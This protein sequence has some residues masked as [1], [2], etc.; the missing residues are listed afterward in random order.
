M[1]RYVNIFNSLVISIFIVI[2]PWE[3]IK[4]V[5]F[6]DKVNYLDYVYYGKNILEYRDF[7]NFI[8]FISNE[9]L[10]H[11]LLLSIE[12]KVN[13]ELFFLSISFF[14]LSTVIYYLINKNNV[15]YSILL[16][17]PL[18]ISMVMSQYRISLALGLVLMAIYLKN[19]IKLWYLLIL[20]ALLIHSSVV[21]F[22]LVNFLI[23]FVSKMNIK[24]NVFLVVIFILLGGLISFMLSDFIFVVLDYFGDRRSEYDTGNI[25]ST[26]S[27]L[28]FWVFNLIIIS[29]NSIKLGLRN[30]QEKIS[31][32]IL[33]V[34]SFNLIF[35][36]YS[37]RFLAVFLPIIIST[38]LKLHPQLKS[39]LIVVYIPY[40]LIQWIYWI[41]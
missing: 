10:W 16:L 36:G 2:I 27:Y 35:D 32:L 26:F 7:D 3:K 30:Y 5:E 25:S 9:W 40:C 14:S 34:V 21:L 18:L 39:I 29:Y 24:N 17:N 23:N 20:A 12:G 37:T 11:Y 41:Q 22:I 15:F 31:I 19:N 8:S 4:G 6:T 28:S 38:N 13:Y 33:S 1:K